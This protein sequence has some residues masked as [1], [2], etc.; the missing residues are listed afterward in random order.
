MHW[1]ANVV[2]DV[3]GTASAVLL[4]A[5]EVV[6]GHEVARGRRPS[7]R[8]DVDLG[9]GPAR[10]CSA[11]GVDGSW[12]ALDVLS[13]AAPLRLLAPAWPAP[14]PAVCVGPRV[15]VAAGAETPWRFWLE[16]EPTLSSSRAH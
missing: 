12:N 8:R 4:R 7:A 10:L 15:G 1:C 3:A 11:L 14:A 13:P 5:G 9:R 2:C 6:E 16:G